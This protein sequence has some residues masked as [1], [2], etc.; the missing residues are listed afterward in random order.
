MICK[1]DPG[2]IVLVGRWYETNGRVVEDEVCK[3]ILS[4]T[5]EGLQLV[6]VDGDR[7][8]ALYRDQSDGRLWEL[9]YPDS[10][11]NGAG[12]PM[13]EH[14]PPELARLKYGVAG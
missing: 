2:E 5:Q 6:Q 11:L 1:L 4:L 14:L 13:L 8:T 12:P 9:S 7:W 3:R 10:A